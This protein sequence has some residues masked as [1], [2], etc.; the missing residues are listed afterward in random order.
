MRHMSEAVEWRNYVDTQVAQSRADIR[1]TE[2][3]LSRRRAHLMLTVTGPNAAVRR[4]MIDTDRVV[5][6]L[7]DELLVLKA[8]VEMLEVLD[9]NLGRRIDKLYSREIT[10]RGELETGIGRRDRLGGP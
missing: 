4:G 2:S 7:E 3:E 10:R 1:R 5:I 9:G 6:N 8:H